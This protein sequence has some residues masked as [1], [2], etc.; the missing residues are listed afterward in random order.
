M[1]FKKVRYLFYIILLM[2]KS[3]V[4]FFIKHIKGEENADS[5]IR[6][7]IY[8]WSEFTI[9]IIGMNIE[10]KRMEELPK[11]PCLFV[12]NHESILDMPLLVHALRDRKII[13][14]GKK[15]ILKVPVMGHWLKLSKGIPIDRENP[16]KAMK[17]IELA[18]ERIK[19]GYS[20]IIFP[21]GT[22]S[23]NGKVNEFKKG[24]FK[25][26]TKAKA[27]IVPV[28]IDGSVDAFEGPKDFTPADI[29]MTFEKPIYTR[30]MV[31]EKERNLHVE[32][33][34]LIAAHHR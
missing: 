19:E 7:S 6:K 18:V 32:V 28:S 13:F 20:V 25:I 4:A 14:V 33:R 5:Y 30:N 31:K 26:A 27:P 22:R 24:S 2:M 3:V 34:E 29:R 21:E 15:E 9:K 8:L 17:S 16:R 12:S 10:E 11:E 1:L 23:K